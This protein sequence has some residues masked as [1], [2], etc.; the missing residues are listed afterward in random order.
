MNTAFEDRAIKLGK[1]ICENKTTIR[2]TAKNFGVSKSTVHKDVSQ[3]L[4][5]LN[6][7]LYRQVKVV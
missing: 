4:K 6:A 3:R 2:E 1:Y 7:N 5:V